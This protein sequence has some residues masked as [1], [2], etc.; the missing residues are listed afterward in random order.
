MMAMMAAMVAFSI[1]AMLPALPE[2]AAELAPEAPN[3]AQLV[4][5]AFMLGLGVGSLFSG[6]LSDAWGRRTVVIGGIGLFILGALLALVA[7]SME[8]LLL[9]RALQ[10]LGVAGPRIAPIAMV[11]DLYAGRHMARITS[12]ITTVFMLV[13]ALA[14]SLGALI[15]H[16]G[17]WR[18]IFPAFVAFA[19]LAGTWM[20]LRQ[21]E[22][23][24][25]QERRPFRAAGLREGFVEVIANPLVRVS[26][27][28]LSLEFGALVAL[29]SST[30]QVYADSFGRG[31]SFP[32]WF[33][34]SALIAAG[35]TVLNATLVMQLG[36]R[37]LV[38]WS[39]GAQGALSLLAGG[40]FLTG[41]AEG[42]AGF[43][44]WFAWSSAFL[45]GVGLIMGNLTA[46]ALQALG[47]V[48]GMAASVVSA[49]STIAGALLAVP[50]GLAFDG[51]PLPLIGGVALLAGPGW[52]LSARALA[53]A[54]R[55]GGA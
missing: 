45:F 29:L 50:V 32:L 14:P 34:A 4:V 10:G 42:G 44:I 24:A 39:F 20:L 26:L 46:L 55:N 53:P 35:G 33:A 27:L 18:A 25:A 52:V 47:H 38:L 7:P 12:F 30:Q 11:R 3:R 9:A 5:G 54:G 1:D 48:A 16:F 15:I 2:I 40:L 43:A 31:G 19:A 41:M 37:R 21:G 22:T 13:P 6:P 49:L 51:T 36:M 23:L 8:L 17:G 28:L